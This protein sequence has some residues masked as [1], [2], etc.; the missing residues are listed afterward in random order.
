MQPYIPTSVYTSI[1]ECAL[2][3]LV[4]QPQPEL[5]APLT[6]E[7]SGPHVAAERR[8]EGGEREAVGRREGTEVEGGR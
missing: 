2:F 3:D 8:E 4:V 5:V 1:P 6:Q 7:Q